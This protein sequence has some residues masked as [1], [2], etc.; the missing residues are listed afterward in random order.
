MK[1]VGEG[2]KEKVI[3]FKVKKWDIFPFKGGRKTS[4]NEVLVSFFFSEIPD[5]VK[6]RDI[7]NLFG[8]H[9]DVMEVVIPSRKNKLDKR[10]GFAIFLNV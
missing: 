10:Y 2:C 3:G 8:C 1:V 4:V 9:E 7:F 5:R 6:A